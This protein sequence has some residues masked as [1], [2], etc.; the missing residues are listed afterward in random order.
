MLTDSLGPGKG[1]LMKEIL[2]TAKSFP[3]FEKALT[4]HMVEVSEAMR[5]IQRDALVPNTQSPIDSNVSLSYHSLF[6]PL[7]L[8]VYM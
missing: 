8:D 5:K 1:T 2:R 6:L 4:V 3:A 7:I